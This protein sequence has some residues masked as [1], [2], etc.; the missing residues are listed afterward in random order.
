[1]EE[2]LGSYQRFG[3]QAGKTKQT[4]QNACKL[5]CKNKF[6]LFTTKSVNELYCYKKKHT[7]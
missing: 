3:S 2:A 4:I 1:M 7:V 6:N 5:A